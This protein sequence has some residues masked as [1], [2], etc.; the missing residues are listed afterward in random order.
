MVDIQQIK[1]HIKSTSE[2]I[3]KYRAEAKRLNSAAA[4]LSRG[5]AMLKRQL[6]VAMK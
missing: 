1:V 2:A 6:K 5:N 4:E 3:K